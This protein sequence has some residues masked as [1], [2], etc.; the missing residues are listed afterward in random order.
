M[1]NIKKIIERV[2]LA[3]MNGKGGVGKTFIAVLVAEWLAYR[4]LSYQLL[5]CDDNESLSKFLPQAQR[6]DLKLVDGIEKMIARI[7]DSEISLADS[8]ANITAE[9]T[10]L[11]TT[12]EFGPSLESIGG[13]LV[14]LVPIV[15]NDAVALD[16]ARRMVAAIKGAATYVV[17]KNERNG[18]DFAAFDRSPTGQ[19]LQALGAKELRIP[20]LKDNLQTLL[21]AD[22]LTLS[23]FVGRF[24]ELRKTDSKTAFRQ[25]VS[26]QAATETLRSIFADLDGL[27]PALLPTSLVETAKDVDTQQAIQ[28]FCQTS[29][30]LKTT[31]VK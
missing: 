19:Y 6:H 5:D 16:E 18:D 17:V 23:Q 12:T 3:T 7:L 9:L 24:W 21:N 2:L 14:I 22:R 26:A 8:P 13:R 11:F 31:T 27:A 1:S 20:R 30:N 28:T 25:T 10:A 15:A 4:L 29:W